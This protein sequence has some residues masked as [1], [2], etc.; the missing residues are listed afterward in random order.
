MFK[1]LSFDYRYNIDNFCGFI[2]NK[3]TTQD[4]LNENNG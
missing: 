2:S 4:F 1:N 3:I